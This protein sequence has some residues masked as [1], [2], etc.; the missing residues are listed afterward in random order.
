M[1]SRVAFLVTSPSTAIARP[2]GGFNLLGLGLGIRH[3]PV[4]DDQDR[5]LFGQ[6][7]GDAGPD[8]AP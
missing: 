3:V 2:P 4:H 6:R 1:A 8:S 5:S 7:I